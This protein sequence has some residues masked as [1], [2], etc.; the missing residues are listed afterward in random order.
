MKLEQNF[1]LE[2]YQEKPSTSYLKKNSSSIELE[3][4]L[5]FEMY[6]AKTQYKLFEEKILLGMN[7][8]Q[9]FVIEMYYAKTKYLININFRSF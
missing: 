7:L 9:N 3:Q 8:G 6:Y 5:E 4:N 1:E 2:M